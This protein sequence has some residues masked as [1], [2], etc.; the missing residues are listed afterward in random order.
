MLNKQEGGK[1]EFS[2]KLKRALGSRSDLLI[3][4]ESEERIAYQSNFETIKI[5]PILHLNVMTFFGMQKRK[6]YLAFKRVKDQFIALD[7]H[8]TL[9]TWNVTSGKLLKQTKVKEG[10]DF[11]ISKG[12]DIFTEDGGWNDDTYYMGWY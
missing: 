9:T 7:K 1:S 10:Q 3:Y 6:E 4:Y 5:V 2:F 8:L 11:G 12:F